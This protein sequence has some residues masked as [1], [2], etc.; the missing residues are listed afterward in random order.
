MERYESKNYEVLKVKVKLGHTRFSSDACDPSLF[1]D[2]QQ[3]HA[4]VLI[5]RSFYTLGGREEL[6]EFQRL[7]D[8]EGIVCISIMDEMQLD[9]Y[10]HWQDMYQGV[11]LYG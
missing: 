4:D 6:H 2:I 8:E 10:L 9:A 1:E 3:E 7:L 5:V 11:M